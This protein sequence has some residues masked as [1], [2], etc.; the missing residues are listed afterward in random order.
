MLKFTKCSGATASNNKF[1]QIVHR[2]PSITEVEIRSGYS[3]RHQQTHKGPARQRKSLVV[4]L[5]LPKRRKSLIVTLPLAKEMYGQYP[6]L[7]RILA[8]RTPALG[9]LMTVAP[10]KWLDTLMTEREGGESFAQTLPTLALHLKTTPLSW[11]ILP[12]FPFSQRQ[13][14]PHGLLSDAHFSEMRQLQSPCHWTGTRG[15][16]GRIMHSRSSLAK[17]NSLLGSC[18]PLLFQ[19]TSMHLDTRYLSLL[20]MSGWIRC[21]S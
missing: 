9:R 18:A 1:R 21:R 6:Q 14:N 10:P 4:I 16:L 5:R 19:S 11:S 7:I 2:S 20:E 13:T 3:L 12:R 8:N 15:D 17:E